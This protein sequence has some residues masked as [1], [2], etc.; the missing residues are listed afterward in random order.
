M[1]GTLDL[2]GSFVIGGI[3]LLMLS[4]IALN[5]QDETRD[6]VLNEIAQTTVADLG[7]QIERDLN[8]IGYRVPG[9]T[10]ITKLTSSAISF[11][12][13]L[14]NNGVVDTVEYFM[15]KSSAGIQL[16]RR[17]VTPGQKP[18][19]WSMGT[20]ILQLAGTDSLGNAVTNLSLVRGVAM[21]LSTIDPTKAVQDTS[22]NKQ[23]QEC[24]SEVGAFWHK[25]VLPPN[26]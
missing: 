20:A 14:D 21:W 8:R 2:L 7:L 16:I 10:K 17:Q 5:L 13:D 3:V 6:T 24:G 9:S 4:V 22:I 1:G 23:M 19:Q 26:F 25:R 11:L 15:S 18:V 12:S